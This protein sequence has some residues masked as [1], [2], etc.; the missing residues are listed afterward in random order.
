MRK[1]TKRQWLLPVIFVAS[2]ALFMILT[3][4][5]RVWLSAA[6]ITDMRPSSALTPVLG[7]IFGIPAAL[8]CGAGAFLADMIS[9]YG[10]TYACFSFIQ[11]IVYGMIPYFLWKK[12]N[13]ERNGQEFRLDSIERMLKFCLVMFIDAILAVLFTGII[14][15]AYSVSDFISLN[16]LYLFFNVFDSGLLF[17]CPL[18]ILCHLIQK[19]LTNITNGEKE[20]I[21]V[22]SLNERMILNTIAIGLGICILVG[23]SVYLSNKIGVKGMPVG[24]WGQ[25]YLF[26]TIALN[27]YFLLSIGFMWF[28]EKKIADPVEDLA[29]IAESYYHE[30]STDEQRKNMISRCEKYKNDNT[31]AG[32]LARSYISMA[33]NLE[34]YVDNLKKI[35][36]EKERINAELSLASSIQAHM[37]P[38]IFPPF[39]DH[40]EFDLYATMTPAKEVGGDF[41]DFFMTDDTHLALVI[42]DVSGK[43]VPAA[44]FM[45][46]AK[47][48]IKNYAQMGLEPEQVFTKVNNLLC[49]GNDAGL[50]VTAWMGILNLSDGKLCFANAGHNPPLL[51]TNGGD[52]E[53]LVSR[54]GFVLAGMEDI[55]YRRNE[56]TLG[57]GDRLFLYTD[58]VTESCNSKEELYGEDRLKDFMNHNMEK[59]VEDMLHSLRGDIDKFADGAPQFDDIT[60]LI[61]DLK[62]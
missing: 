25:M 57:P 60:M 10:L 45:V 52:F 28:T 6:E 35:T 50:F 37:L 16:S 4:P 46:I 23:M 54:P 17:G 55:R 8:G 48:L 18:V 12:L 24:I 13:K 20:K 58:G 34:N 7:M 21:F 56:I 38:I 26:Q 11:Q 41:Y 49:E 30:S 40:N 3:M 51:R 14:N 5:F 31:E 44:L 61:M 22:F 27:C 29:D 39:P 53:Y 42:A 62:K 2:L 59:S 32:S 1:E 19:K 43:G 15:H 47:T 36:A 33:Q 9:G